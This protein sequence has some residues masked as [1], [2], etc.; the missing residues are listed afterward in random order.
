MVTVCD[1][2]A[3]SRALAVVSSYRR[4]ALH[5]VSS[6][7]GIEPSNGIQDRLTD[8]DERRAHAQR[9]PIPQRAEANGATITFNDFFSSQIPRY[10]AE[11]K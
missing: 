3:R 5:G 11:L 10:P 7:P 6:I 4:T 8:L 1:N 2:P 9:A